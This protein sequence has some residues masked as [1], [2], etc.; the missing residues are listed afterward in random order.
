[1]H[2]GQRPGS[3]IPRVR[4]TL[5]HLI[6]SPPCEAQNRTSLTVST[7]STPVKGHPEP[8]RWRLGMSARSV[9]VSVKGIILSFFLHLILEQ[10]KKQKHPV[11]PFYSV[12]VVLGPLLIILGVCVKWA[13][14]P[15]VVDNLVS[16]PTSSNSE[17]LNGLL[18]PLSMPGAQL[19]D[20]GTYKRR[21]LD[22][23]D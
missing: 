7:P 6:S 23:L 19:L 8:T 16:Q 4:R 22:R 12:S 9:S 20:P 3:K 17:I 13:I 10:E 15:T 1:M 14:F 5:E 18:S 21:H 2:V 11:K